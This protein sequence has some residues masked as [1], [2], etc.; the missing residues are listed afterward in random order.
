MRKLILLAM[1]MAMAMVFGQAIC[2][3]PTRTPLQ[4]AYDS[5]CAIMSLQDG[6]FRSY[7]TGVVLAGDHIITAAHC[8]D[9]NSNGLLDEEEKNI[10]VGFDGRFQIVYCEVVAITSYLETRSDLA[11]LKPRTATGRVGMKLISAAK[12]KAADVGD[13]LISINRLGS[14][15]TTIVDGYL[16]DKDLDADQCSITS[17][18]GSSG[19]G[20]YNADLEL[21]GIIESVSIDHRSISLSMLDGLEIITGTVEVVLPHNTKCTNV[22][23]IKSFMAANN[24]EFK[25]P[26]LEGPIKNYLFGSVYFIIWGIISILLL[27]HDRLR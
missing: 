19:G 24:I 14:R 23:A 26:I 6:F 10:V 1:A 11:I 4:K 17:Y 27:R 3:V 18:F 7:G 9:L 16:L 22:V 13:K 25:E 15:P 5:T 21:M 12:Y 20:V 8:V 2:A